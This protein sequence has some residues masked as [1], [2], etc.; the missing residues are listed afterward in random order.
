MAGELAESAARLAGAADEVEQLVAR[1]HLP[2]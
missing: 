1:F 2:A